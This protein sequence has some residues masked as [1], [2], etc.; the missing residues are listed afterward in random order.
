MFLIPGNSQMGYRLPLESLP[1][2]PESKR[3]KPAER[4]PF[5]DTEALDD[6]HQSVEKR[7]NEVPDYS[8]PEEMLFPKEYKVEEVDD[9]QKKKEKHLPF[10]EKKEK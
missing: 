9:D 6:F 2:I 8:I 1:V 10:Q 4:S 5:E 3:P 7:S